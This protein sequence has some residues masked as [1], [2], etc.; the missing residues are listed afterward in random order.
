MVWMAWAEFAVA[1]VAFLLSHRIPTV[2]RV[3]AWLTRSLGERAFIAVYSLCSLALLAWLVGAA[4]RAPTVWLWYPQPWHALV[5]LL[6]MAIACP[7]ATFAVGAVNPL[8]FGGRAQ[9]ARFDPDRPGIAGIARHGL[10]WA[11]ALWAGAHAVANGDLAHVILFGSFAL[12][13]LYGMRIV[14]R[15][16]QR[17]L[18]AEQWHRLARKTSLWPGEALMSGRWRPARPR[19][20]PETLVRAMLAI[21]LYL[22]LLWL[23]APVI[24][25]PPFGVFL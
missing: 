1:G 2:P 4:G 22:A 20:S 13:A 17:E 21:V 18:G 12:F 7:L 16:R 23:H 19:P 8:S 6:A 5:P 25:V 11:F 15:R 9:I 3:R 10:L 14:D 24:G